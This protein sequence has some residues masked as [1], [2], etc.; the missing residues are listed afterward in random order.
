VNSNNPGGQAVPD[1][2]VAHV[3]IT[4]YGLFE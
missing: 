1:P 3:V 4:V 2:L